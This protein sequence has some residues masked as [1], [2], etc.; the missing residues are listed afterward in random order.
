[1]TGYTCPGARRLPRSRP[2]K[3]RFAWLVES[4]LDAATVA[5]ASSWLTKP[6]ARAL[7]KAEGALRIFLKAGGPQGLRKEGEGPIEF[8]SNR[9]LDVVGPRIT[10]EKTLLAVIQESSAIARRWG[11]ATAI[12][13]ADFQE[14][15]RAVRADPR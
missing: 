3:R 11:V 12:Q 13:P 1:V 14:A 10:N 6:S 2:G 9:D 5:L 4:T 7:K 8:Q 15:V